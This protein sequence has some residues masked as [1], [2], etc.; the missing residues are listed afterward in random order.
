MNIAIIPARGGSKRIPRKNIREF[1]GRPMLAYPIDAA[2][3]TGVFDEIVVSTDDEEIAQ[4]AEQLGA[5]VP[6]RRSADLADDHTP[7]VPVVADAIQRCQALGW[8]IDDVCCIYPCVPFIVSTD[9]LAAHKILESSGVSF[10]F[11]VAEFPSAVQ[12]SLRRRADGSLRPMYP[13]HVETKTQDL[14]AAYYDAGQFYWGRAESWLERRS[15]HMEAVGLCLPSTRVVDIDTPEDWAR[16]EA[17]HQA[18]FST[19][20]DRTDGVDRRE[21]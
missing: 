1:L 2:Q 10:S 21:A 12:R 7:T 4:I 13:E 14:E 20:R 8:R 18:M 19:P 15:L 16:A 9:I 6:F 5:S 11:P 3:R 17:L